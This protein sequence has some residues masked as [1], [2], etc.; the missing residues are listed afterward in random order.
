MVPN[1]DMAQ[2]WL[3]SRRM[4]ARHIL[5]AVD[6][7]LTHA[8]LDLVRGLRMLFDGATRGVL[9]DDI[10]DWDNASKAGQGSKRAVWDCAGQ[11]SDTGERKEERSHNHK[12]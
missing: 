2:R 11:A 8:G 3:S 6:A 7:H 12:R 1:L 4:P 10:R 5:Y 9:R